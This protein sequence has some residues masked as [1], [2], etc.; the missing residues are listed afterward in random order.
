MLPELTSSLVKDCEVY[1]ARVSAVPF[2][3]VWPG[4]VKA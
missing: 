1:T 4:S 3:L 2:N